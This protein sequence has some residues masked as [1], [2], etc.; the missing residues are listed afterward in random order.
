[1]LFPV[2]IMAERLRFR[3]VLPLVILGFGA[4]YLFNIDGWLIHDD[5]GT[6]FYEVW[7]L[8][9]GK[10]PGVDFIA[11]QQPLFLL[12][13]GAIVNAFGRE[14]A[15]LRTLAAAQ[16]LLGAFAL[17]LAVNQIWNR[18]VSILTLGLLLG[19]SLVYDQARLFRPDPMMFAWE[20][21]AL[22]A[23]LLAVRED[24]NRRSWW[25]AAGVCY[26]VAFLWKPFA[27]FPIFGLALYFAER[28][29]RDRARWRATLISGLT[30][31]FPF[32]LVGA[33]LS[34]LLH[35]VLGFYYFEPLQHHV[36]LG[37]ANASG[38]Q[39]L[40][41]VSNAVHFLV[42]N[43]LWIALFP[44]M[45]LHRGRGWF[46]RLESRLLAWQLVSTVI[47]L[48]ITRPLY[49][50][51][52]IYLA[53]VFAILFAWHLY[54]ALE[55]VVG[56]PHRVERA[57][58]LVIPVV[59]GLHMLTSIQ[60]FS[61]DNLISLLTRREDSTTE[62]AKYVALE[63]QPQAVVLS[64]Y[65]AINFH[66]ARPSIYEASIIAGGRI[67]GGIITGDLLVDRIEEDGVELVL[68]H[69]RGGDPSPDHMVKLIDYE[70]FRDHLHENFVLL[71]TFD[72]E[73]QQ[74]EVY[75]RDDGTDG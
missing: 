11:E 15:P 32:L 51:Y 61:Q 59:I 1:M 37:Q 25:A 48:G 23:V 18:P 56:S 27:L 43:P 46:G 58:I 67:S 3:L 73:G 28:L 17:T 72:R 22:S 50:R 34:F 7:Q 74:I 16:V 20:L 38:I 31:S 6:D 64:D 29:W 54:L 39:V 65:A 41:A 21:A 66:A 42:I 36:S 63:S 47:F 8:Q 13:G 57:L 55:N 45:W 30:F 24:G 26:G 70:A 75:K 10:Q 35:A 62:L 60:P 49:P 68:L 9:G 40:K 44:L 53:P 33:G 2:R 12:A 4:L 14:A 69:V 19:S 52:L 5:E 71:T